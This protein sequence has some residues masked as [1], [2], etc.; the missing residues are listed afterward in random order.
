MGHPY[1][2]WWTGSLLSIHEARAILPD[3]SATTIQVAGSIMGAVS[4]MI[5]HPEEGVCVPDDLPWEDVLAVSNRY[6]GTLHSGPT[7]WDPV[8]SRS[9]LFA[10]FGDEADHVDHDDPWQ[11]TNFLVD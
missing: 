10:K 8:S 1:K 6:L 5:E 11:F 3:Q 7:D 9:D 2:A 4:W